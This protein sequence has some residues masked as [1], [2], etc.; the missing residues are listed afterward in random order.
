[1][2]FWKKLVLLVPSKRRAA[3]RDMREELASLEALAGRGALGNLTLTAE[4][5][6]AEFTWLSLE[7]LGQDLRYGLRSMRRDKLFAL[8]TVASLALGIGANTA[9]YSF[10][11][12]VLLRP[13]PVRD[14]ES[15]V[16]LKWNARSY[17]LAS[18]GMAWST[19]GSSSSGGNTLSSIF[20]YPTLRVF[21]DRDDVL[22]A[23][24]CYFASHSLS[25]TVSNGTDSLL[26]QY[27]SDGYFQGMGVAPAA[28]RLIQPGDDLSD[29]APVV[30]VSER[31]GVRHFGDARAAV[32]QTIRVNDQ[33]LTVIGVAPRGFFG[34]EPG[35]IPDVYL[36]LHASSMSK[37]AGEDEH[38][39]WIEI[40]ARLKPGVSLAQ[41][42]ARLAPAFLRFAENSATTDE[43]KQDLPQL[44]VQNGSTGLDSLRRRYAQP[45]Y[46]L[47]TMVAMILVI[48]C[49][50]IANLLLARSAARRREIAIRLGVGASR[51][52]VIRQLLTESLLLSTIGGAF[53]LAFAWWGIRML[54][55]L[56]S[57][58]RDNFTLHAELRWSVL[59]V[60]MALSVLTGLL[61]GLAPAFQA[62]R[63]DIAPAL[64]DAGA[65][66]GPGPSRQSRTGWALVVTQVAFSLLLL[67][68][69]GLFDRTLASLHAIPLGFNRE[70][71]LLFTIRP[72]TVGYQGPALNRL[73]ESLRARLHQLPGVQDVS[74]SIDALP[75]GG[76]TLAAV[77]IGG[78]PP[79][80]G[81]PHA[82]LASVGPD[83]FQTMQFHF[84][85]G[86]EFTDRDDVTTPRVAVVNRRLV[87][88]LG[89]ANPIGQPLI[90]SSEKDR[91]RS[92]ASSKT[93]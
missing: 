4:D 13:L 36:P 91:T 74:L 57:N 34:A 28:G 83:F 53:G 20:P 17:A 76:G 50:N 41:A 52:R 70:H 55:A 27:V 23:A 61:F 81:A 86:R 71:V 59:A 32:G 82:V 19:E 43:Q 26:G 29:P 6:R 60:T 11:D 10:M 85:A 39:Y 88:M 64:K 48:A 30:V 73:Y 46:V 66:E 51:W 77:G 8:L 31:F 69:A 40:M 65:R 75:M 93:P 47:M 3:E 56:L 87:A 5:A 22:A 62:T 72:Y 18:H 16:V 63:V 79:G 67:V 35:A 78:V 24:F 7:R 84:V 58:G 15:L 25:V 9:V 14:P 92:S 49:A 2:T 42:Q 33:P 68:S 1:M 44:I 89:V 37:R 80:K 45:I 12:S 90:L 21:Q 38:F 54:T